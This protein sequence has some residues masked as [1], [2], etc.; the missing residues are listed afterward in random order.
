MP[1]RINSNQFIIFCKKLCERDETKSA[2]QAAMKQDNDATLRV[3][4][5][6]DEQFGIAN[7]DALP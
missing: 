1:T 7:R 2:L 5:F 3:P 6:T 4:D